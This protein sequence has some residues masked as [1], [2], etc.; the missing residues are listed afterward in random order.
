[1]YWNG[2]YDGAG[3]VLDY[4]EKEGIIEENLIE[5]NAGLHEIVFGVN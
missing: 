5:K 2:F 3:A 4:L 1:M